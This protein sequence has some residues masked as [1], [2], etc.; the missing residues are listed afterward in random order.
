MLA[1]IFFPT[2]ERVGG[3]VAVAEILI[4]VTV[5]IVGLQ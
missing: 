2:G 3:R 5:F 4:Y 1:R